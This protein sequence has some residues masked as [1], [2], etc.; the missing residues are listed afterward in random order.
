MN[1]FSPPEGHPPA[2]PSPQHEE[3]RRTV[4]V[5]ED[6]IQSQQYMKILLTK[7]YDVEV[8]SSAKD[9]WEKL[10]AASIDLV[11]MDISLHG[12]IDG[13]QLTRIIRDSAPH[14]AIPIIALTAHAFPADRQKSIDAGCTD[15]ISKPFQREQLLR[16]IEKYLSR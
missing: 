6:D 7:T 3:R 4:L 5:V 12:D 10:K 2:A 16:M 14:R 11:L 15:Y 13:L 1:T 9:A 8:S